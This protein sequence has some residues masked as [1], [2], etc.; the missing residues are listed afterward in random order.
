MTYKKN[1]TL[2]QVLGRFFM[3][4]DF[5]SSDP[6]FWPIRIRTQKK[7]CD[8]DPE[9]KNPDLKHCFTVLVPT[10]LLEKIHL[11][12]SICF[13][14]SISSML[15]PVLWIRIRMNLELLPGSGSR[16]KLPDSDPAKSERAYK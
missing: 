11:F 13:L 8:P 10:S 3:D 15:E 14:I 7:N 12:L 16:I 9:N 1:S 5:S 6:D 2:T 4:P